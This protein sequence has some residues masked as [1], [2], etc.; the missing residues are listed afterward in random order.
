MSWQFPHLERKSSKYNLEKWRAPSVRVTST[1][2]QF[3]AV[4]IRKSNSGMWSVLVVNL[5]TAI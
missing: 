3:L 1:G 4:Y 5:C 2:S